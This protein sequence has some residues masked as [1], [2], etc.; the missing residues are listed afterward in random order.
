MK[1]DI[2]EK[3]CYNGE[4]HTVMRV[5]T[6]YEL[7]GICIPV[8]STDCMIVERR[9]DAAVIEACCRAIGYSSKY[10][11][12]KSR[13]MPL[14]M[15]R[16]AIWKWIRENYKWT[17]TRLGSASRRDHSTISIGIKSFEG[18]LE[19][20]DELAIEISNKLKLKL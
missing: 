5:H 7:D 16:H 20:G 19:V 3:V 18:L 6:L 10:I 15:V 4:T 12:S 11:F 8:E 17:T 9:D 1:A 14:P 2:N 13:K